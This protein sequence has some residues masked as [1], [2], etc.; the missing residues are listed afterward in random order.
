MDITDMSISETPIPWAIDENDETVHVWIVQL[1]RVSVDTANMSADERTRAERFRF[2]DDRR[3]FENA[4]LALRLLLGWWLNIPPGQLKFYYSPHGKPLLTSDS[5]RFFNVAHS[6][7]LAAIALSHGAAVGVD[8]EMVRPI[9][10]LNSMLKTVFNEAELSQ[11]ARAEGSEHTLDFYLGWTRKEAYLKATGVGLTA[12][13]H[14]VTVDSTREAPR[15]LSLEYGRDPSQWTLLNLH[16]RVGC[17]GAV[18]VERPFAR[19]EL[20][21]ELPGGV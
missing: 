1:E 15:F 5:R 21:H 3:R 8:I 12:N 16:P 17:V 13:L 20:H 4:R 19:M 2:P 7:D 6:E 11:L 10:R 9:K 18:A 14:A